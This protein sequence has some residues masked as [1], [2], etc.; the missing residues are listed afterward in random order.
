ME[1]WNHHLMD[2]CLLLL[3]GDT[4]WITMSIVD[5]GDDTSVCILS[6]FSIVASPYA[7]GFAHVYSITIFFLRP[8][9]SLFLI[10]DMAAAWGF[11]VRSSQSLISVKQWYNVHQQYHTLPVR[12]LSPE[13]DVMSDKLNLN[14]FMSEYL[15]NTWEYIYCCYCKRTYFLDK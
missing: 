4:G 3:G 1:K 15:A 2:C 5:D 7:N 14:Y 9:Y 8:Y 6:D 13:F 12:D 11:L 10:L